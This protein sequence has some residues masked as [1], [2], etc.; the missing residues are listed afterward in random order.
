MAALVAVLLA[1]ATSSFTPHAEA[2]GEINAVT[3]PGFENTASFVWFETSTYPPAD[4]KVVVYDTTNSHSPTH[5][6]MLNASKTSA[7]CPIGTECKDAVRASVEQFL[8]S[9]LTLDSVTDAPDSLSAWWFV[10]KVPGMVAYSLH[11]GIGFTDE[12]SIEYW[13]GTSDLSNQRYDLGPIPVTGQWF[14]MARNLATDIQPLNITDPS[15]TRVSYIW[16]AA[17][18]NITRGEIAWLDDVSVTFTP[19]PVALFA[20]TSVSG[21]APLAVVF[22]ASQS[23]E[24]VVPST[25][26]TYTWNFGDGT[27]IGSGNVVSHV[28]S[29][30]G[31]YEV[32]LTVIDSNG[33]TSSSSVNVIVGQSDP[34]PLIVLGAGLVV[35]LG[36]FFFIRRQRRSTRNRKLK[37]GTSRHGQKPHQIYGGAGGIRL[38][39]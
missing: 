21:S 2:F 38:V 29:R 39:L 35:F 24:T 14:H 11:V 25:P 3:N 19:H 8:S 4:A 30:P 1:L 26:L 16:F 5:S 23:Y 9:S 13:Y 36:S 27:P 7:T 12:K 20:T 17:F 10:Q 31:T 28:Y 32:V 22:N 6:A 15:T 37:P 34:T 18:G 33:N